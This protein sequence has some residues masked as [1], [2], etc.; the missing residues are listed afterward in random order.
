MVL[1]VFTDEWVHT[2]WIARIV[3]T[4]V[5][6]IEFDYPPVHLTIIITTRAH[7]HHRRMVSHYPTGRFGPVRPIQAHPFV[8]PP[9]TYKEEGGSVN[10]L[11]RLLSCSARLVIDTKPSYPAETH[12]ETASDRVTPPFAEQ[13]AK[14]VELNV[15][16]SQSRL[17]QSESTTSHSP[18]IFKL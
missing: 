7:H 18:I 1:S 16:P 15:Q 9:E 6:L 4:P 2:V 11:V 5:V 8:A 17:S 14:Y 10:I 12:S 13:I 3:P